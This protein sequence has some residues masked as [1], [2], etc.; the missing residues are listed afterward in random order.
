MYVEEQN[1]DLAMLTK[2]PLGWFFLG[3]FANPKTKQ[4]AIIG[5]LLVGFI[6]LTQ[7]LLK[8]FYKTTLLHI[9][10]FNIGLTYLTNT[11]LYRRMARP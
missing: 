6:S 5:M 11:R 1:I 3:L 4:Q 8:S 7:A 9:A 2:E 10:L